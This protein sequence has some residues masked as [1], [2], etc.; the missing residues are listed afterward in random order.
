MKGEINKADVVMGLQMFADILE[1]KDT[2]IMQH[3]YRYNKKDGIYNIHIHITYKEKQHED[4][5][6]SNGER[7]G[8]HQRM[9][10]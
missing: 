10:V 1:Q 4:K 9:V 8:V 7:E 6:E 3:K 2:N 5:S